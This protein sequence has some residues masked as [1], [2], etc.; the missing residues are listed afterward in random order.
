VGSVIGRWCL[1]GASPSGPSERLGTE[2]PWAQDSFIEFGKGLG[3]GSL[4]AA[5]RQA[6]CAATDLGSL[7]V[8]Q[9]KAEPARSALLGTQSTLTSPS[10]P[11]GGGDGGHK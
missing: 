10:R 4:F 6:P 11:M 2:R 9:G 8:L 1:C 3:H 7:G 5:A